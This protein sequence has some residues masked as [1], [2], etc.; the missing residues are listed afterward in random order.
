MGGININNQKL[1]KIWAW[2]FNPKLSG[3]DTFFSALARSSDLITI[4]QLQP[5]QN[6]LKFSW[7]LLDCV[8]ERGKLKC[9]LCFTVLS[10]LQPIF[11][12]NINELIPEDHVFL[13]NIRL[14]RPVDRTIPIERRADV[15]TFWFYKDEKR[16]KYRKIITSICK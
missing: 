5:K 13:C 14:S 15:A 10:L 8:Q 4:H 11:S 3:I 7:E 1:L 16:I 6:G 12:N 2:K 9:G